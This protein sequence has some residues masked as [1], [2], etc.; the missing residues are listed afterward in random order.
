MK[1]QIIKTVTEPEDLI[2]L[3]CM[4]DGEKSDFMAQDDE[5]AYG[6]IVGTKQYKEFFYTTS[7]FGTIV[8]PQEFDTYR[9]E[10]QKNWGGNWTDFTTA[11]FLKDFTG[12]IG[13]TALLSDGTYTKDFDKDDSI[14]SQL[15]S[16]DENNEGAFVVIPDGTQWKKI[17]DDNDYQALM[18]GSKIEDLLDVS[19]DSEEDK[20]AIDNITKETAQ[21]FE[22]LMDWYDEKQKEIEEKDFDNPDDKDLEL[23]ILSEQKEKAIKAEYRKRNE[24]PDTL[25]DFDSRI[26]WY[27]ERISEIESKDTQD[28]EDEKNVEALKKLKEFDEYYKS[29]SENVKKFQSTQFDFQQIR[30]AVDKTL[31]RLM[32]ENVD[33]YYEDLAGVEYVDKDRL[34]KMINNS[35][36]D[37]ENTIKEFVEDTDKVA[38]SFNV[39][40]EAVFITLRWAIEGEIGDGLEHKKDWYYATDHIKNWRRME[41][42]FE[43]DIDD[44]WMNNVDD[45]DEEDDFFK[46]AD[47]FDM[48]D[49][50]K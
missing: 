25:K 47:D 37:F 28:E 6:L 50:L 36:D 27:D 33:D 7:G 13:L 42:L 9:Q 34:E 20:E 45:E 41:N 49:L 35:Y 32:K 26:E 19:D 31:D 18:R 14:I 15:W 4:A 24:A 23:K 16:V 38:L 39:K 2:I 46:G 12:D 48:N 21:T 43:D 29:Q 30:E 1:Q 17:N 10:V 11:V 5:T 8:T 44:D 3:A 40:N 22:E